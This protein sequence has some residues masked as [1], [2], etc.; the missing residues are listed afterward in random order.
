MDTSS[1]R[2]VTVLPTILKLVE[3][4]VQQQLLDFMERTQQL[5]PSCHAYRKNL[6][7]KT[8]LMDILD[9]IYHGTDKNKI[10][11]LMVFRL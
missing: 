10:T 4:A 5:N 1:Y 7:T 2:P 9:E 3:R 11:Y 6:S 8:T